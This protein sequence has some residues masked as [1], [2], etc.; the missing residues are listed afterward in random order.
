[1]AT[2]AEKQKELNSK[3]HEIITSMLRRKPEA[4]RLQK[5]LNDIKSLLNDLTSE[6]R[7]LSEE[8]NNIYIELDSVD[9]Q[10]LIDNGK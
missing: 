2:L 7:V 10:I 1:M 4:E 3:K 5:Q 8:L 6:L 9:T